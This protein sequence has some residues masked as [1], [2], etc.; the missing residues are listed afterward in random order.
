MFRDMAMWCI[1]VTWCIAEWQ[2]CS[3]S[4]LNDCPNFRHNDGRFP[5]TQFAW[6]TRIMHALAWWR[7]I[8]PGDGYSGCRNKN[9]LE[10]EKMRIFGEI[11][12]T[13]FVLISMN[14]IRLIAFVSRLSKTKNCF[15]WKSIFSISFEIGGLSRSW[16]IARNDRLKTSFEM[17]QVR[18]SIPLKNGEFTTKCMNIWNV[19]KD[20]FHSQPK[21]MAFCWY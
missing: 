14:G 17:M 16:F 18:Y 20:I 7:R 19:C 11:V 5:S 10:S 8:Y 13:G 21:A 4:R 3:V 12:M 15:S 6:Q 2:H 1:I 9:K